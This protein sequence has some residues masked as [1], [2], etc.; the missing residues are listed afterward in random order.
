MQGVAINRSSYRLNQ[1][2]LLYDLDADA[3]ISHPKK[4]GHIG[5]IRLKL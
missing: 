5:G 3:P 2:W 1:Q 4:G